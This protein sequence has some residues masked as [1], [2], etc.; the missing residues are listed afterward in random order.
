MI[1]RLYQEPAYL[2]FSSSLFRGRKDYK[3]NIR[4]LNKVKNDSIILALFTD[5]SFI[6]NIAPLALLKPFNYFCVVH[7]TIVH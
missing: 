7:W 4:Q 6:I 2:I 1:G 5:N 3:K